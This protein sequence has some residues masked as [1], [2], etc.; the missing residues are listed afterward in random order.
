[1]TGGAGFIGGHLVDALTSLG[2]SVTVIDDLSNSTP[3]HLSELIELDPG[4]VR[5]VHGSILDPDAMGRA[6]ESASVVFHLAAIC[7]V[8]RSVEDPAR[9][10]AVNATGVLRT[11]EAARHGG[12]RRVV[13]SASSS[14]YGNATKMP[15]DESTI[16]APLSPYAASKLAG[17]SL[18][19]SYAESY[20]LSTISLRYFNVFGPRQPAGSPYSGVVPIFASQ[21]MAGETI[22]ILGDGSQTRDFTFVSNAVLANLLAGATSTALTGQVVNV[23]AGERTSVLDLARRVLTEFGRT[24]L[25]PQFSPPRTGDVLHSCADITRAKELLGYEPITGFDE[26]LRLTLEWWREQGVASGSSR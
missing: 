11:L 4:R 16:P 10:W 3:D 7:S 15:V 13:F 5:F 1:M 23:G 2:A 20:G 22:R 21:L 12:A 18:M 14:A 6:V 24:D 19:T 17:E 9:S 26:G 25:E 8:P